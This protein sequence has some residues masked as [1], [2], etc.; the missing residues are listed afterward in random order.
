VSRRI[1]RRV[2]RGYLTGLQRF[3]AGPS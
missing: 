1:Q 2:T 3:V